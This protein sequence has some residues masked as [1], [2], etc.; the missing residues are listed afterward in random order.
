M[1]Q[2]RMTYKNNLLS[3]RLMLI[4]LFFMTG[5][6]SKAQQ[7]FSNY[8]KYELRA[9][10]L[11]TLS[12]LD[13]PQRP[14]H[15]NTTAIN[16]QKEELISILDKLK[17]ANINT[18]LIQTRIR[19]TV[20][21]PS[22]IEP[23]DECFSGT[24]GRSPG[25]DPLA[26]AID[27]CHKRGMEIHAWVVVIPVGKWNSYGCKALHRKMPKLIIKKGDQGYMDP[28]N[29][30]TASY[31][32]S[33]CKEIT[34]NYDI[35]GIHL[36]Y[37]RYPEAYRYSAHRYNEHITAIVSAVRRSILAVKPWVK[38][39]CAAIG[40]YSDLPRR[41]SNG[42]SALGTGRQ[43]AQ[44]WLRNGLIDQLYPMIY[45][46]NSDF[47]PF[48]LDWAENTYG[49]HLA[50]G[51]AAYMLSDK[52]GGW[53]L[54][55]IERQMNLLRATKSGFAF[56]RNKF[57]TD[58]IKGLYSYVKQTFCPYPALVP[59]MKR[60][61]GKEIQKPS[62]LKVIH[63]DKYLC[64]T[65][66]VPASQPEGGIK[67]NV[68]ASQETNVDINNPK[69][70]LATNLKDNYISIEAKRNLN[71][72]VTSIDRYGNESAPI[73]FNEIKD[74][75]IDAKAHMLANDGGKILIP[76]K[77]RNATTGYVA[78]KSIA[79]NIVAT[80]KYNTD[81]KVEIDKLKPGCY[82][83]YSISKNGTAHRLG[84][85]IIKPRK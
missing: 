71:F 20:I 28:A 15:L 6:T 3:A 57:L 29:P 1:N 26:F 9:V 58:N 5:Y 75:N 43:D 53:Q 38:L 73:T 7:I 79:G 13:W 49:G 12:G 33:L 55:E 76:N 66:D 30:H 16:R 2:T 50:G 31:M 74:K 4:L 64:L 46:R 77:L 63:T 59:P 35:D 21:Y 52:E 37:I 70:L 82:S 44:G 36:D 60:S 8:P 19:A 22:A 14:T 84:F 24:Y 85:T 61:D 11:T 40:K 81:G 80:S 65:W 23:W 56:F 32:A 78:F 54:S 83:I 69:N 10:W 41:T 45:F 27:E 51:L 18:V 17:A 68:Y 67:F 48:A 47:V 25:Y 62:G 72:A 42:W 39:S 34:T